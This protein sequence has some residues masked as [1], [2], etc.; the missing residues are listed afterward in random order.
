MCYLLK[1]EGLGDIDEEILTAEVASIFLHLYQFERIISLFIQVLSIASPLLAELP[2]LAKDMCASHV[3]R[4][5]LSLLA[6]VFTAM[7]DFWFLLLIHLA[8]SSLSFEYC[9][10][11]CKLKTAIDL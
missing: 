11:V 8:Q 6:G 1:T 3:L 9:E 2:W 7:N 10:S 5:L 4:S